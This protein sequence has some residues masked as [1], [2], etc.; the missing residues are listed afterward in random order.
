MSGRT[1]VTNACIYTMDDQDRMA[2]SM[3][4]EGDRIVEIDPPAG[5]HHDAVLDLQGAAVLPGLIDGHAHMEMLAYAWGI[6][7]DHRAP[8]VGTID[9][10]VDKIRAKAQVTPTGRWILGQGNHYQ[11]QLLAEKRYPD[12]YD[13]DRASPDHPIVCR[14]SFHINVL[15]SKALEVLGVDEN[16]PDAGG[17]RLE[18]DPETGKLTGRTIDMWDE[19]N[20]PDWPID[21]L[22]PALEVAQKSYLSGGVTALCEFT[23]LP[24]GVDA[25]LD[26]AKRKRLKIRVT[27]YPKLPRVATFDDAVDGALAKRYAVADQSRL[28]M[29]GVKLFLDGGLTSRAAA[30]YEP[31]VGTDITGN[32]AFEPEFYAAAVKRLH[33]AGHQI[34]VHAIGDRALDTAIDAFAA[35]GESREPASG[36]HRIE[37]AG[38]A[39]WNTERAKR[40]AAAGILPVPQPPFIHTT[41]A[42][43]R[44]NLG[45]DRGK[46]LFP[47]RTMVVE[48]GF[49][50]PGN[51]DAIGIHPRQH[52]P[53]F[54]MYC[55]MTR[56]MNTGDVLDPEERLDFPTVLKMYTRHAARAIGREAEIGSL[57]P[58][59]F[60]DFVIMERDPASLPPEAL[61]TLHATETWIGG[62]QAWVQ[63]A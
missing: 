9:Q 46:G 49:A 62:E 2:S 16:T 51:S 6:A 33:E 20:G 3:L 8:E 11:D 1:L 14:F 37:H 29:G 28:R 25:F 31:Y 39:F 53:F 63:S 10:L 52:F 55:L 17:G 32:L 54:G 48:Q 15:N 13:L 26:M 18:R 47:F 50:V 5:V 41:A 27:A 19:I 58:G 43:Y 56:E 40:F 4:I 57:E 34:C 21:E 44:K 38:N 59:K 61:A 7:V 23:M 45:P 36:L 35:L 42:G 30:M 24:G 60:A 22:A 12:R